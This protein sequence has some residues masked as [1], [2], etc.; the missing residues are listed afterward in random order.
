MNFRAYIKSVQSPEPK[1]GAAV[2][3]IVLEVLRAAVDV[4]ELLDLRDR[5][6]VTVDILPRTEQQPLPFDEP[7]AEIGPDEVNQEQLFDSAETMTESKPMEEV[8]IQ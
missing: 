8:K 1:D 5:G 6:S 3:K 4:N 2:V 7:V